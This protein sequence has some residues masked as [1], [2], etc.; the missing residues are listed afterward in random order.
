MTLVSPPSD[1]TEER[2][3]PPPFHFGASP[4]NANGARRSLRSGRSAVAGLRSAAFVSAG[5]VGA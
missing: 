2:Q 1:R 3:F 4:P 5:P